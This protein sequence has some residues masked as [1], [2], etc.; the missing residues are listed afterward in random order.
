[1]Q[2]PLQMVDRS[3]AIPIVVPWVHTLL[4]GSLTSECITGVDGTVDVSPEYVILTQLGVIRLEEA[5][6]NIAGL[7]TPAA[8][9]VTA[10]PGPNRLT[11]RG[12]I[13]ATEQSITMIAGYERCCGSVLDCCDHAPGHL[14]CPINILVHPS[15]LILLI[16]AVVMTPHCWGGDGVAGGA[17]LM[18]FTAEQGVITLICYV[19][20]DPDIYTATPV[21]YRG[22]FHRDTATIRAGIAGI[23]FKV[24]A[25]MVRVVTLSTKSTLFRLVGW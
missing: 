21:F 14:V 16:T 24:F 5:V 7:L 10:T 20:A 8:L 2:K 22:I 25:M 12:W 15:V 23:S 9:L 6:T 18:I 19:V 17:S 13:L 4:Y 1:M 3:F 11:P